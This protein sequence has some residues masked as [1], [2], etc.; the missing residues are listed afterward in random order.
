MTE[1]GSVIVPAGTYHFYCNFQID[2]NNSPAT[3]SCLNFYDLTNEKI[4]GVGC[5]RVSPAYSTRTSQ[6]EASFLVKLEQ[7]TELCLI[8]A[9]NAAGNPSADRIYATIIQLPVGMST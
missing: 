1:A 6:N 5:S 4:L 8:G 2:G 3:Y 7:D 9:Y